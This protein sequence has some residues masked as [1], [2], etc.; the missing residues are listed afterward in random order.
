[1]R[2]NIASSGIGIWVYGQSYRNNYKAIGNIKC[3]CNQF[4]YVSRY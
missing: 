1:M 2:Y 4:G 3:V